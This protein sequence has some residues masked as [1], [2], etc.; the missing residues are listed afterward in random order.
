MLGWSLGKLP[1]TCNGLLLCRY[2][3]FV[4][5]EQKSID[6]P[7]YKISSVAQYCNVGWNYC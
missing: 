6:E 3:I 4:S 1:T 5:L 2:F 7:K